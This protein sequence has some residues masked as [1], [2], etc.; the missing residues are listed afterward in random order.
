MRTDT[1]AIKNA[2][3]ATAR[4]VLTAHGINEKEANAYAEATSEATVEAIVM[5][6]QDLVTKQDLEIVHT[7]IDAVHTKLDGKIDAVHMKLDEKIDAVHM[8]LDEKIDAVHM[9]LDAKIDAVH[10]KLDA[11]IDTVV[12]G[13][14]VEIA[15]LRTEMKGDNKDL[16]TEIAD[17]RTEMAKGN[18]KTLVYM[19]VIMGLFL[20][21]FTYFN[22]PRTAPPPLPG[23]E[24][25]ENRQIERRIER[26]APEG[27]KPRQVESE[28]PNS[29]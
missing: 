18:T 28:A 10:T 11:K 19:T 13:L 23:Y 2:T 14:R 26:P 21:L 8:K 6:Q 29:P 5:S 9:K 20:S 17:L 25:Q 1:H 15:D 4:G 3:E 22:Q 27:L 7:E 16:R 24:V 12:S